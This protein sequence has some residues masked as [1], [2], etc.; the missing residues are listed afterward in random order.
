MKDREWLLEHSGYRRESLGRICG[1]WS[2]NSATATFQSGWDG[3]FPL[4]KL[5]QN[6]EGKGAIYAVHK[7]QPPGHRVGWRRV[8]IEGQ[9]EDIQEICE[10]FIPS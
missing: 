9:M 6:P 2:R 7:G 1:L 3:A 4:A 10:Q 5:N 8:V